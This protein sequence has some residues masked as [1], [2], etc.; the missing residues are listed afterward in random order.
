MSTASGLVFTG[1]NDG[2]FYA[3]ESSTGKELWK[4]EKLGYFHF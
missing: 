3:F 1:D 2:Y 4:Q